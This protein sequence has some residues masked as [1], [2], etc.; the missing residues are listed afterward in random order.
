[1]YVMLTSWGYGVYKGRMLQME[2]ETESEAY[3]YITKAKEE[4]AYG[5]C[6]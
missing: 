1:M 5:K 3:A 4:N 6:I 2:F